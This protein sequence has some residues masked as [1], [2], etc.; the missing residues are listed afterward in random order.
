MICQLC[1]QM[2]DERGVENHDDPRALAVVAEAGLK[3]ACALDDEYARNLAAK[4]EQEGMVP[5]S[6]WDGGQGVT[7][8]AGISHGF[9]EPSFW[10]Y[11]Y[12]YISLE[13]DAAS[14]YDYGKRWRPRSVH[15][16]WWVRPDSHW[17]MQ[18]AWM[19]GDS[20]LKNGKLGKRRGIEITVMRSDTKGLGVNDLPQ[21]YRQLLKE[22]RPP[23]G[24]LRLGGVAR[25]VT[26]SHEHTPPVQTWPGVAVLSGRALRL[27]A[28]ATLVAARIPAAVGAA[29]RLLRRAGRAADGRSGAAR[30]P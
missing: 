2:L 30:R 13:P 26:S 6:D 4:A 22:Y 16:V 20:V 29:H 21:Q 10:A 24:V 1:N 14:T 15:L 23:D 25:N 17:E 8:D 5:L 3:A 19:I 27:A 12:V 11:Y 18:Q 28:D 7:V 9:G